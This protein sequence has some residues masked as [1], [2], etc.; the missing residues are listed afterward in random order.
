MSQPHDWEDAGDDQEDVVETNEGG[1]EPS[2]LVRTHT[3]PRR[4][5][6]TDESPVV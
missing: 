3:L 2:D 6:F 4:S 1:E 5:I